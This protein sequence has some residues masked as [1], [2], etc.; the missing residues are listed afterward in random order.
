MKKRLFSW[1]IVYAMAS[2]LFLSCKKDKDNKPQQSAE[3]TFKDPR[4]DKIYKTIRIGNQ[5]WFAENLAY[6]GTLDV[7]SSSY[8]YSSLDSVKKYG[9]MY[10]G[11]AANIACPDRWHLPSDE[12]WKEL[13]K[14][15]GMSEEDLGKVSFSHLRGK[16]KN[17]A[18][19]LHKGGSSK[20]ESM[21]IYGFGFYW[22]STVVDSDQFLRSINIQAPAVFRSLEPISREACVRCLQNN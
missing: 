12:E 17:V 13:E 21:N 1:S 4:D 11:D 6:E 15:L 7:G 22:T 8:A 18:L 5:T 2:I 10:T 3:L 20:F 16:D 14:Y 19:K 9:M